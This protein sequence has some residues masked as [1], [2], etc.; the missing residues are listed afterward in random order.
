VP[1]DGA[2]SATAER[3]EAGALNPPPRSFPVPPPSPTQHARRALP[4]RLLRAMAVAAAATAPAAGPAGAGLRPPDGVCVGCGN[5]HLRP[6]GGGM[7][8]GPPPPRP[9]PPAV[10]PLPRTAALPPVRTREKIPPPAPAPRAARRAPPS[11]SYLAA[12]P[13]ARPSRR[14]ATT[15]R[16]ASGA[17][18]AAADTHGGRADA[19]HHKVWLTL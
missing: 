12:L 10:S 4:P 6:A 17:A 7:A 18:A 14:P 8:A 1:S 2:G 11:R 3:G 15:A 19:A 13:T 5:C 9:L 16:Q